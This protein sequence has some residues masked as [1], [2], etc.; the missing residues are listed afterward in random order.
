MLKISALFG[1]VLMAVA[2]AACEKDAPYNAVE[3]LD[4]DDAI[5]VKYMAD[6][7]VKAT[8]D[9]SGLYYIL[10]R[11]GTSDVQYV[12]TTK[13]YANYRAKILKDTVFFSR[14]VDST[15]FFTM[16]GYMEGWKRGVELAK[17]GG[18]VRLLIPSPLAYQQRSLSVGKIIP[19]NSILDITLEIVSVNKKPK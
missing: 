6:S 18:M 4:I 8:K 7:N 14:S 19:P 3:Q 10:L 1:F 11:A 2:F 13:I 15:F 9:V 17:L 5:I 12:D 16:P